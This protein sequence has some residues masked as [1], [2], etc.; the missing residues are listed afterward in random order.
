MFLLVL[1]ARAAKHEINLNITRRDTGFCI[2]VN[3]VILLSR[4]FLVVHYIWLRIT[5]P[6]P[7]H[8]TFLQC[9]LTIF[10]FDF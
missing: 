5:L 10:Y 1:L 8:F 7:S 6:F 2:A 4:F 3:R 9:T